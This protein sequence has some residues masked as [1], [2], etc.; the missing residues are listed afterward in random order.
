MVMNYSI[1]LFYS[2]GQAKNKGNP[3]QIP[4]KSPL[5]LVNLAGLVV[6]WQVVYYFEESMTRC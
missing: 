6:Y 2:W 5:Q 4:A 1:R 3:G